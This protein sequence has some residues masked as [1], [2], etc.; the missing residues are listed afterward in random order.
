MK[1][2]LIYLGLSMAEKGSLILFAG[3]LFWSLVPLGGL[4]LPHWLETTV[5]LS[6]IGA[7]TLVSTLL[8]I[9]C[10]GSI[11]LAQISFFLKNKG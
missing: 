3:G 5:G 11:V 6:F 2:L 9:M 8:G 7:V 1:H 4:T 10:V